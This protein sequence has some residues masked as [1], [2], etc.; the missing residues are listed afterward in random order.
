MI[1]LLKELYLFDKISIDENSP[2]FQAILVLKIKNKTAAEHPPLQKYGT[3]LWSEVVGWN[4]GNIVRLGTTF[5]QAPDCVTSSL[6]VADE[7][8]TSDECGEILMIG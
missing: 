7:D 4:R 5:L 6:P 3:P 1:C 2:G 8:E